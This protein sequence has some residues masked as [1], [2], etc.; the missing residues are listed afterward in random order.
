[1]KFGIY[2]VIYR[3]VGSPEIIWEVGGDRNS[4]SLEWIATFE[5]EICINYTCLL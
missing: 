2:N 4:Y 3:E 5:D 1:M